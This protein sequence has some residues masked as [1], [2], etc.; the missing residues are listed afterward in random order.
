MRAKFTRLGGFVA[1]LGGTM[2]VVSFGVAQAI[3]PGLAGVLVGPVVLLLVGVVALQARHAI[4]RGP[5]GMTGFAVTIVGLVMLAYGSVG[6]IVTSGEILGMAYGPF[7]FTGLAPGALVLGAG[8]VMTA[9]SVIAANVMPRLSPVPLLIGGT[10]VAVAGASALA[11]RLLEG[12]PA[13]IFPFQL[14]PI[15]A[16]WAM[17][18]IGWLWLGY[19]LWS[20]GNRATTLR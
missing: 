16:M 8:A 6:R 4:G 17:F 11:Q 15:A 2:W 18:G 9:I 1:L 10:G 3:S 13:D 20:E 5:L 14:G 19:L 12:A 7:V